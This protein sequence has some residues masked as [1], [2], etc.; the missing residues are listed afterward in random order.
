MPLSGTLKRHATYSRRIA[1][2]SV[3]V[4]AVFFLLF[5]TVLLTM[6]WQKRVQQHALL[7]SHSRDDL[8]QVMT[9]LV[10]TLYP[11]Q[12]YTQ[13]ECNSVGRE[14]TSRAAFA[15][16]IRAILLVRGGNAYCSSATG[17]FLLPVG[18]ISPESELERDSDLRLLEGTPL[19][20]TKPALALWMKNP[21][22]EETGILTTMNLSLTPYQLLASYH[23]EI[24]GMA[25]IVGDRAIL[26][27]SNRVVRVSDLPAA[28]AS[29]TLNHGTMQFVLY[30]S[31]LASRDYHLI[32]L[33]GLLFSLLVGGACWLLLMMHQHPRKEIM[34]GIKRGQF[35]VEYQPLVTAK[36]GKPY[37]VEAL[38]RWTHPSEGMIPPDA[39]I[40]YAEA[41]NL[42]I[43]L[44][45]HLFKL[46]ARDAH[47]MCHQ[48]PRG[49]RMGL[50][51]SPLHLAADS[52]Q[53][54]VKDWIADM[55]PNH[56]NY[57]FEITE[58][59]MVKEKNAGEIFAWLHENDI[60]IAI[61][62]FGTGHSALIYLEKYPF[63]YLKIDRG[64][65]QS[66][67]TETVTSPVL[68]AVLLLAKKLNLKTVAEG[69]ETGD[70]A[71]WLVN[72]GVTHLQGYLF[73][74]PLKP[75]NLVNY[76]QQQQLAT[77]G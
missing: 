3:I 59:T 23:P 11:L 32:I 72:R 26:S 12:Q 28:L 22:N 73:S 25:L 48:L 42:I 9:T 29:I 41:Q 69:V 50:N 36:D 76:Y 24:T 49:T 57:V 64:F 13:L 51:L 38:L 68:D 47:Q 33:S 2:S 10:N 34:Q 18:D 70:Q 58:R 15:G 16:N 55:P 20:P 37:G 4:G 71:A 44:T 43:P 17:A 63:D 65:V 53:Q 14:L 56:F 5:V 45:R 31:T 74:R 60:K 7:L 6:T 62:D 40:S 27:G 52:F 75:E 30:G 67:G 39:F 1:W 61:D 21:G 54:D 35:H 66:I 46:V 77:A 8:Q 19:Q